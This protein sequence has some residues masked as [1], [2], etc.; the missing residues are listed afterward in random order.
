MPVDDPHVLLI[1]NTEAD[2]DKA[3]EHNNCCTE[4]DE[5]S[6]NNRLDRIIDCGRRHGSN[7]RSLQANGKDDL[8]ALMT[9]L[10]ATYDA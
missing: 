3:V 6:K 1:E 7:T 5:K 9:K 2:N 10:L 8:P 4:G